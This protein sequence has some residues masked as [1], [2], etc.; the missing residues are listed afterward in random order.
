MAKRCLQLQDILKW[1]SDTYAARA[2]ENEDEA[3]PKLPLLQ[4]ELSVVHAPCPHTHRLTCRLF[5]NDHIAL[6]DLAMLIDVQFVDHTIRQAALVQQYMHEPLWTIQVPESC[7]CVEL[8]AYNGKTLGS[9]VSCIA[10]ENAR[11]AEYSAHTSCPHQLPNELLLYGTDSK[12]VHMYNA[13]SNCLQGNTFARMHYMHAKAANWSL[14][15]QW[16]LMLTGFDAWSM[17]LYICDSDQKVK[18]DWNIVLIPRDEKV[19]SMLRY[20]MITFYTNTCK[21]VSSSSSS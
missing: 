1:V 2:N 6:K 4:P 19:I 16:N 11:I 5:F 18:C 9:S 12:S 21:S 15:V 17:I 14:F 20:A 13:H 10:S 3:P 8:A 7:T